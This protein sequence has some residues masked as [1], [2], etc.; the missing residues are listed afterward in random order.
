MSMIITNYNSKRYDQFCEFLRIQDL[1]I[2]VSNLSGDFEGKESPRSMAGS[3]PR[4]RQRRAKNVITRENKSKLMNV[5]LQETPVY[6][7]L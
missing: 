5:G 2:R 3:N 4:E 6:F 1:T 7:P